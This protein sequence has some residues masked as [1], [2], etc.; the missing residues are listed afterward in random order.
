[1]CVFTGMVIPM[2]GEIRPSAPR[3]KRV[4]DRIRQKEAELL[5]VGDR[6]TK[7]GLAL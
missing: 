5:S 4:A 1:M 6:H 7:L 3:N 2:A